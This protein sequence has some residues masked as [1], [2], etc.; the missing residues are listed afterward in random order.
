MHVS[1]L[2]LPGLLLVCQCIECGCTL[3]EFH[4][5]AVLSCSSVVCI[6]CRTPTNM[7]LRICIC[8]EMPHQYNRAGNRPAAGAQTGGS[9][10]QVAS[11]QQGMLSPP[12]VRPVSPPSSA[13]TYT[14]TGRDLSDTACCTH[15]TGSQCRCTV[16]GRHAGC[17]HGTARAGRWLGLGVPTQATAVCFTRQRYCLACILDS[18]VYA[19]TD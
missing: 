8:K 16:L 14:L 1:E 3:R 2:L 9:H 12:E 5:V 13:G 4:R 18:H 7:Y 17:S 15:G 10:Q 19:S 11:A 6:S